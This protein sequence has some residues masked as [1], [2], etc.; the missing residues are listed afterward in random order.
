M[1]EIQAHEQHLK[2]A[3]QGSAQWYREHFDGF[4]RIQAYLEWIL[5]L[6]NRW[7][8]GYGERAMVLVRNLFVLSMAFFPIL[9]FI[10]REQLSLPSGKVITFLDTLYFSLENVVPAGIVS[11]MVAIGPMARILAGLESLFG[12]VAVALFAAYVFRWSLHR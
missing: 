12:V 3:F 6:L 8:W 7:L 2:A 5:S 10:F 4:R 1:A 11:E 9:F